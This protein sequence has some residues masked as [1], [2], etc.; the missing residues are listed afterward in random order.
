M[1]ASGA[2]DSRRMHLHVEA[3]RT[4]SLSGVIAGSSAARGRVTALVM[5]GDLPDLAMIVL[6]LSTSSPP[7]PMMAVA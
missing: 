7:V 1:T 3:Q 5:G 4:E 6:N 2:S